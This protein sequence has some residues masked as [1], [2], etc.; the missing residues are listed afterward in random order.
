MIKHRD[1]CYSIH[2]KTGRG[3]GFKA[4]SGACQSGRKW[5]YLKGYVETVHGYVEATS[6]YYE[7]GNKG[8]CLS[9]I[10]DGKHY[11]R[12]FDKEYTARGLVTKA[13]QFA[14]EVFKAGKKCN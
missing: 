13:K 5:R 4:T 6:N 8:S 2:P 1:Q 9:I 3:T 10:K 14:D 11:H 12:F 7:N